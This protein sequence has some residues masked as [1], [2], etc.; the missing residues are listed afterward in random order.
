MSIPLSISA[1]LILQI[2]DNMIIFHRLVMWLFWSII[3]WKVWYTFVFALIWQTHTFTVHCIV[4]LFDWQYMLCAADDSSSCFTITLSVKWLVRCNSLLSLL[5]QSYF[6]T[7]VMYEIQI[8]GTC[9]VKPLQ[10]WH[11]LDLSINLFHSV[12]QDSVKGIHFD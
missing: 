8:P 2:I 4:I 6:Q 3:S 7:G 11:L 5:L 9:T 1:T 12:K 10:T